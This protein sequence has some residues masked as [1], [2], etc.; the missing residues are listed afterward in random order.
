[1]Q[2]LLRDA[3]QH[4]ADLQ[5]DKQ[6]LQHMQNRLK[7]ALLKVM[8]HLLN[9]C[10]SDGFPPLSTSPCAGTRQGHVASVNICVSVCLYPLIVRLSLCYMTVCLSEEAC[11][12]IELQTPNSNVL[13][14]CECS[15]RRVH[16]ALA[17]PTKLCNT[18][19]QVILSCMRKQAACWFSVKQH[20][21]CNAGQP[22]DPEAAGQRC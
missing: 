2:V 7:Q 12:I 1:M 10:L 20:C 19:V 22:G 4:A 13:S 6:Q 11:T 14:L 5:T 3:R 16:A 18:L 9:I 8:L 15:E 21:A 17:R